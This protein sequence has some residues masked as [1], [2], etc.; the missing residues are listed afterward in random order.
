MSEPDWL[1]V[2]TPSVQLRALTWGRPDDP[3]ALC[4]HGFPDTA[5][6]WR[7]VAPALVDAGWRVVAPFMRGYAPS[8]IPADGSYHVGTLMNDALQVLDAAGP[9][10]RDVVVGHD[11][12]AATAAGLAAMP[13]S[14]F[15]ASVIMSVPPF[16]AYQP[17]GR[18]PDQLRLVAQIPRQLLRSWYIM[19]FQ[20]PWLPEFSP[21]R[22]VP[23]L[24]RQ[25]SPG[26]DQADDD[27]ALVQDAI[28]AQENWLAAISMYRQNFRGTKPPAEYADLHPLFLKPPLMPFLYLHGDD[29]GCM[30][31]DYIAWVER[32][33]P[34]GSDAS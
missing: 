21:S 31:P 1:D 14:P 8:S 24:W 20:L 17:W 18:A 29:D 32:I 2:A 23:M 27:V 7:K 13:D 6:G 34:S 30:A 3:I 12:G 4:L 22:V 19:Y 28:G 15:A 5:H 9:T 16:A 33:L 10:G 11:W 26:Y 25:W